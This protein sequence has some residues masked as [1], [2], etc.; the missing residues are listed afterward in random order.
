MALYCKKLGMVLTPCFLRAMV[1][2]MKSTIVIKAGGNTIWPRGSVH[3]DLLFVSALCIFLKKL[4]VEG[5]NKIVLIPGGVGGQFF[6]EWARTSGCSEADLNDI[7]CS[8]INTAALVMNRTLLGHASTSFKVCPNLPRTFSDV[9][10]YSESYDL[11]VSGVSLSGAVTSDSLAALMAES[12]NANLI[13]VKSTFPY[14]DHSNLFHNKT[15]DTI[16][17]PHLI[18]YI[19]REHAH[20]KAGHHAS[21]DPLALLIMTR[22][23]LQV[24][25]VLKEDIMN[26][27]PGEIVRM[28]PIR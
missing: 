18:D 19:H 20:G 15:A 27:R 4:A 24:R 16:S 3:V 21:F 7:G 1:G 5:H 14:A 6:I 9:V 17:L 23:A 10:M 22:S 26:S 28:I 11:V 13:V 25:L 8:L 12:I 2:L